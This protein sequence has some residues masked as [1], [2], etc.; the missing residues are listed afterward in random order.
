MSRGSKVKPERKAE[1]V[2]MGNNSFRCLNCGDEHLVDMNAGSGFTMNMFAGLA[3][4]YADDHKNCEPSDAGAKRFEYTTPEQ[5]A[6]SWDTGM[7]SM[8][9][10][11]FMTRGRIGVLRV[12]I[13]H[14]PSDFGRCY[15]LLKVAPRWRA[16]M[17]EM[18]RA[19]PE[20]A[21]LCDAWSELEALYEEE[22]PSG[23][24]PKLYARIREL[25]I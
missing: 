13:P 16:M 10:Y 24:A 18:G 7:S 12:E 6:K 1:H 4:G 23:A 14:D 20:W 2:V 17:P 11:N 8:T 9:I 22:W 5:W 19:L 25:N 3:R 21:K 15:R